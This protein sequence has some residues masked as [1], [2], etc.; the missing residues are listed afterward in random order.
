[1][2]QSSSFIPVFKRIC[3]NCNKKFLPDGRYAKCCIKCKLELQGAW[4]NGRN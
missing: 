3:R 4:R 2:E 1:M